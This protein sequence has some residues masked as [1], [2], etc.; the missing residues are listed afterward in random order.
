VLFVLTGQEGFVPDESQT[1]SPFPLT[2][3][4]ER[5]LLAM[6]E[7]SNGSIK[8]NVAAYTNGVVT[9]TFVLKPL[10]A[11]PATGDGANLALWTAML[12]FS[13]VGMIALSR[14]AKY[15]R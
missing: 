3:E 8:E 13:A 5:Q 2:E 7:L 12:A 14:K 1:P 10:Q 4:E 11:I 15:S 9:F 6:V